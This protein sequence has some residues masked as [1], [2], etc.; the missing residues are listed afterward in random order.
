MKKNQHLY[1]QIK[2]DIIE[3]IER[4]V[5]LPGDKIG[6]E[7]ELCKEFNV[8][9]STIRRALA[10]LEKSGKIER[11]LGKGTFVKEK[12]N[13]NVSSNNKTIMVIVPVISQD[14][15]SNIITGIQ[16]ATNEKDYNINLC[17]TNN[18]IEKETEYI[19]KAI[20]NDVSGIILHPTNHCYYNNEVIKLIEK[21]PVIMTARYYEYID[22][23]FVV[24]DNYKGAF[25]AVD[26]LVNLGHKKIGLISD[27]PKIQTSVR[28]R[29]EGYKEALS[30]NDICINNSIIMDD[31][32]D[33][34]ELYSSTPKKQNKTIEK[35]KEYLINNRKKLSA[36]FAVNDFLGRE[37][38]IA[39]KEIGISIPE[40]ISIVGFDNV[41]ISEKAEPPLTTVEWSQYKV[42]NLAAKKLINLIENN[43]IKKTKEILP[44]NLV[45]RESTVNF[46][47]NI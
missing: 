5:F 26:F 28:N 12:N 35:I 14:F 22:C 9:R 21:K 43:Q 3:K 36:I 29:I 38:I 23:N 37:I 8:S 13:Y 32:E 46:N 6:T 20:K 16:K 15:I 41:M 44:V 40:E 17:I 42:G 27:K 30:S 39:A 31:L 34:C 7:K 45:K 19:K 11:L 33:P 18:S 1:Q 10:D 2:L 47:N 24:P 4:G 25:D